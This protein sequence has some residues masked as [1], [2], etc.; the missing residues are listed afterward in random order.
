MKNRLCALPPLKAFFGA[1]FAII[2]SSLF[3]TF[4]SVY[5]LPTA[6]AADFNL[7]TSSEIVMETSTLRVLSENNAREKK[8]MASTTKILTA[9]VIIENC[10]INEEITVG[11]K[12]VGVEGSSI[13]LEA[14]EKLSVKD[15]L[16]GLMLRS[17][18]DCAE[19]LAVHLSGSIEKFAYLMNETAAKIGAKDSNFVNPHG[20]HD[21]N[22]YTTAYDLALISC[23]AIKNPVFKEIVSTQKTSIPFTTRNTKRVLI[24]KNKMLKEFEGSTGI[25]T[26]YTKKAGRCLVSSCNRNGMELV[27]VVLNCGPMFERSKTI[28]QN[29]FD[30]YKLYNLAESDNIIDFIPIEN[31]EDMC[32]VYLKQDVIVPLTETEMESVDVRYELPKIIK[33]GAPKDSE[34]GFLKIYCQNN[35]IF[36]AKIYTIV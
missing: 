4:N 14:G 24:N 6:N 8:Y 35:L 21:D 5:G 23:Y 33:K 15:L 17:G 7:G 27:S 32:G 9:L 29:G 20:L 34:I 28:L 30:G 22:H 16:Y 10:D 2:L 19:T 26:G 12:T 1:V 13:Y 36:T 25:K 18:N 31:S 3:F 11:T